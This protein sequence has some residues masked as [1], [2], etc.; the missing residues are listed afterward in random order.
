MFSSSLKQPAPFLTRSV[1]AFAYNGERREDQTQLF[2]QWN[3]FI[4]CGRWVHVHDMACLHV[5]VRGP[6]AWV[7]SHHHVYPRD[8][9]QAIG[10]DSKL[11]LPANSPALEKNLNHICNHFCTQNLSNAPQIDRHH[12][13]LLNPRH[14]HTMP[15]QGNLPF[16]YMELLASPEILNVFLWPLCVKHLAQLIVVYKWCCCEGVRVGSNHKC[17]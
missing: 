10:F 13:F 8:Q 7:G 15:Y 14:T 6:P 17:L 16:S 4:E 2:Q 1:V 12:T 5:K 11:I 9:T 3:P